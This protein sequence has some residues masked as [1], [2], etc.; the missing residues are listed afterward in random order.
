MKTSEIKY[1]ENSNIEFKNELKN[2]IKN[3]ECPICYENIVDNL[4]DYFKTKC[5][6]L[7]HKSCLS[8]WFTTQEKN[9]NFNFSCPFCRNELDMKYCGKTFK[10]LGNRNNLDIIN[11]YYSGRFYPLSKS[12]FVLLKKL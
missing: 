12:M 1:I 3:K 5:N 6:H 10:I 8:K 11:F 9:N 2:E 4:D 7:F